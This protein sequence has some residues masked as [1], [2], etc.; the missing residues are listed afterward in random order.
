MTASSSDTRRLAPDATDHRIARLAAAALVLALID[1]GLPSPLPG[2]KPG[3]A[4]I[5][6]LI[7]LYRYGFRAAVWVS[8]LRIAGAGLL[9]GSLMTPGFFLSL[10][11]GTMSLV[12]LLFAQRLPERW[13]GPVSASLIAAFCHIG[14]QLVLARAILI[15]SDGILYFVPAFALTALVTGTVNGVVAAKLLENTHETD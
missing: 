2:V 12:G 5:V 3:L 4:N 1:A 10:S 8:L 6:T 11:G 7:A 14:G 9:L 13:F 15:P